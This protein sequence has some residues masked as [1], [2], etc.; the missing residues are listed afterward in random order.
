MEQ[1][2][3]IPEGFEFD[4]DVT[5]LDSILGEMEPEALLQSGYPFSRNPD[6]LRQKIDENAMTADFVIV[7]R[8][9]DINR[10][11][12]MVQI[13]PG[14]DGEGI[15]LDHYEKNPVVYFDHGFG[16]PVPIARSSLPKLSKSK[17]TATATFSQIL[18]EAAVFFGL[19][20]EGILNTASVSFLPTKA[21]R[22]KPKSKEL[23]E[24]EE[25][26]RPWMSYDFLSSDLLEWSVVG[27][28]ADPGA[29][30]KCLDRRQIN[31]YRIT[32]RLIAPLEKMAGPKPVQSGPG[33]EELK[34]QRLEREAKEQA[35]KEAAE[36]QRKKNLEHAVAQANKVINDAF[37]PLS[38]GISAVSQRIEKLGSEIKQATGK[39]E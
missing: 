36:K 6:A 13:A 30:R 19:I 10:N 28:P 20:A 1:S 32:Q 23:G 5:D 21:R 22:F 37:S 35:A 3:E 34:R 8:G 15:K 38:L 9:T 29:V 24:D 26:F 33:P 11:G 16:F 31:G 17:A 18:P 2:I 25:D 4:S 7:T 14:G 12:H 27:V 39:V